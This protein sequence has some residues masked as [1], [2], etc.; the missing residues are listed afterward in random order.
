MS[1]AIL[2]ALETSSR[3]RV[4]LSGHTDS[5][6]APHGIAGG[7]TAKDMGVGT[8][9]IEAYLLSEKPL[10]CR[11]T[12]DQYSYY[13]LDTTESR[14]IDQVVYKWARKQQHKEK[15]TPTKATITKH[16]SPDFYGD[17]PEGDNDR[18]HDVSHRRKHRPVI[19]VDQLWLWVLPDGKDFS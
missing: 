3:P 13:M 8:S 6:I 1:N 14:D 10:H 19:M 2:R 7:R 11:R 16:I 12:L 17:V 4:P 18:S 9:L 15:K 5:P